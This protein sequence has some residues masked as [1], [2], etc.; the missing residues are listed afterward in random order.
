MTLQQIKYIRLNLGQVS[1][2]F[3]K[4]QVRH[5]PLEILNVLLIRRSH[6][7]SHFKCS[8]SSLLVRHTPASAIFNAFSATFDEVR[9]PILRENC[10]R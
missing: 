7:I 9:L 2:T 1:S 5:L 10:S 6:V 3:P 8:H 4:H